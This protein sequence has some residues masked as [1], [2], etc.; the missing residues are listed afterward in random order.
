MDT[1]AR[2]TEAIADRPTELATIFA[3]EAAF[4]AFYERALPQVYGYL[5]YRS[6][7]DPAVT[8]EL[9][10]LTFTTA[11]SERRA[12]DGRSDPVTW[13]ISI[14]RHKLADH[15]RRLAREE[16]RRL[17]L[18]VRE[19]AGD[20]AAQPWRL[21]DER[22]AVIAALSTLPSLQRAVLILHYSDGLPVREVAHQLGK[23]ESATESLMT[24]ARDA[25]RSAYREPTDV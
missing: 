11:V 18:V 15:F 20:D 3:S 25:F 6:G 19:V 22:H 4:R 24:R 9:T 7:G 1:R 12:F 10:Q 2:V 13:L 5:F 14:A 16:S 17:R 8:E 21:S 23:S